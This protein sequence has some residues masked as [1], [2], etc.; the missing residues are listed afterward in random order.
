MNKIIQAFESN[1]NVAT[2]VKVDNEDIVKN[3]FKEMMAMSRTNWGDITSH[4]P[5]Q[6]RLKRIQDKTSKSPGRSASI[7]KWIRKEKF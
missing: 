3:A 6:K 7:E 5:K 2:P 4:S 1:V